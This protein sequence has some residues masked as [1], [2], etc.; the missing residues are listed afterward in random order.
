VRHKERQG[1]YLEDYSE[2]A[3]HENKIYGSHQEKAAKCLN[4]FSMMERSMG[5]I[6]SGAKGIG[7]SLFAKML[8][9]SAIEK[10]YP[11]IV[12][13]QY[14]EGVASFLEEIG[15]EVVVLFDEFDKTFAQIKNY[16]VDA[17]RQTAMLP[18]FEGISAGKKLFIV[19]CNE[20]NALSE[21]IV[22]R[23]GRF[24]YHF[25]FDHP[26]GDEIREY[27]KEKL[28]Q[29]N[30]AEI[31]KIIAF[32][33]RVD[34]NYDCLRAIVFEI[35][36]GSAFEEAIKDLNIVNTDSSDYRITIF[37]KDGTT[38]FK[39]RHSM[40]M[41]GDEPECVWMQ[42]GSGRTPLSVEFYPADAKYNIEKACSYI[43][44]EKL[45]I[46][47]EH[48]DCDDPAEIKRLVPEC[49]MI[50]RAAGRAIHYTV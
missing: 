40:N 44:G 26:E 11:L 15:Q 6:L 41:F 25:R 19:T 5:V 34:L 10:G 48:S 12:V 39:R 38:M 50:S 23:P 4:A 45:I 47:V 3:I 43:A 17:E 2:I 37:F 9:K 16:E 18:L 49:L 33:R 7:K 32:S 42:D 20:L 8:A 29:E 30:W 14:T 27:L 31:D 36:N 1:F 35:R 13:D 46:R 24:H 21:F 22:N 28:G